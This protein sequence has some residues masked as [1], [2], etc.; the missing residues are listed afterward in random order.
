[1]KIEE[2]FL[3]LCVN[4][5]PRWDHFDGVHAKCNYHMMFDFYASCVVG[6]MSAS[7]FGECYSG[8]KIQLGRGK[9]FKEVLKWAEK[10]WQYPHD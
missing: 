1:M 5:Y 6:T 9:S 2:E 10:H 7:R 8:E 3:P 4:C